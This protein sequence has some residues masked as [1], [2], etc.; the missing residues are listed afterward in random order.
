MPGGGPGWATQ[1]ILA[2]G[3]TGPSLQLAAAGRGFEM[4]SNIKS[5]LAGRFY[6][7]THADRSFP[8]RIARRA[9]ACASVV[10]VF[11]YRR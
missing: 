8:S 7:P 6:D 2:R 3:R 10:S 1:D 9:I 5:T 4:S 11:T